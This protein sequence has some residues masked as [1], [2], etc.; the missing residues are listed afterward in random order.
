LPS[1]SADPVRDLF[2]RSILVRAAVRAARTFEVAARSSALAVFVARA[3]REGRA[4]TAVH[5]VRLAGLLV[6]TALV[7]EQLLIRLVPAQVRPMPPAALRYEI[8]LAGL[9]LTIMAPAIARAWPTSRVRRMVN[10]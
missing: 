10:R 3:R 4:L 7:T 1:T 9:V 6:L 5:R 8:A 2:A